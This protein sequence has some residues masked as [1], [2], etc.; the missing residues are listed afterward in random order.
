MSAEVSH[1]NTDHQNDGSS[2]IKRISYRPKY[3][4]TVEKNKAEILGLLYGKLYDIE[5]LDQSHF[6]RLDNMENYT[7]GLELTEWKESYRTIQDWVF[8]WNDENR[9]T[10]KDWLNK[11]VNVNAMIEVYLNRVNSVHTELT[12]LTRLSSEDHVSEFSINNL[13]SEAALTSGSVAFYGSIG[14]SLMETGRI[15]DIDHLF[16]FT[17]LYMLTDHWLDDTEIPSDEKLD[18]AVRLHQLVQRPKRVQDSP[19]L[20]IL[21]DRLVRLIRDLPLSHETLKDAFNAEM[22]S[23]VIQSKEDLPA[24]TYLKICEWK[25]GSM[26]QVMQ[27]ICGSTPDRSG[28]IVGACIQLV[29]DMHDID[30]DI[31]DGIHTIATHIKDRYGNLDSLLFYTIHLMNQLDEKHTLFK[32]CIMSMTMHSVSLIPYFSPELKAICKPYFP[33][34]DNK[35]LR[36]RLYEQ[37]KVQLTNSL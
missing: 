28:Y 17:T 37:M 14:I 31:A 23:A 36:S 9:G 16:H 1:R 8:V 6:K 3:V 10:L 33:L 26:V 18:M 22:L 7:H 2:D 20:A 19:V 11:Y 5:I 30:E 32:P 35:G 34:E 4:P 12:D 24:E 25:G 15:C 27:T 13:L 21:T 29:D